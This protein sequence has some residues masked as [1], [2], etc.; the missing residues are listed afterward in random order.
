MSETF[1][2]TPKTSTYLLAFIVSHYIVVETSNVPNRPFQI[3]ARDNIGTHGAWSLDVGTRLLA[4]MEDYTGISYYG[5]QTEMNM[6]QAAI[7]D[8][9]AGAME[10]WGL[11]TYRYVIIT[12]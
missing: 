7:P 4:E 11:L 9:S 10:N 2:T 12:Y 5:M 8:F 6:K 3:F 1:H